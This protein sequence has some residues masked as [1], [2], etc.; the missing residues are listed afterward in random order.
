MPLMSVTA[1]EQI[2]Q[3]T[4]DSIRALMLI[5][6]Y[7]VRRHLHSELDPLDI[8]KPLPHAELDPEAH[9]FTN[10]DM[11]RSI[12]INYV[13]GLESATLRQI[14]KLLEQTY[15]G[16]IGVEFMHIQEPEEKA[17]IQERIEGIRNRTDFP[18]LGRRKILERLT[19]AEVF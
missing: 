12:F 18:D 4:M 1:P 11:D 5:R 6:N 17:W 9:G 2:R 8:V 7:R 3:A 14:V 19:Q 16:K 10:A 15:C 13:L